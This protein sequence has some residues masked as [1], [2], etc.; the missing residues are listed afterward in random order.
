[1][2]IRTINCVFTGR[3]LATTSGIASLATGQ[4]DV[5]TSTKRGRRHKAACGS[6]LTKRA[7]RLFHARSE[8]TRSATIIGVPLELG[9][10]RRGA[11]LGPHVLRTAGLRQQLENLGYT[12]ADAG[13]V[14]V[15]VDESEPPGGPGHPKHV[16]PV[17]AANRAIADAVEAA[18]RAESY[19]VVIGGDHSMAIGV[20]AGVARV[21]GVQ[22]VIWIDAHADLNTPEGSPT[23]N[24]H[25]M[26]MAAAL[27]LMSD[28]FPPAEFPTPAAA[29]DRLVFI[30]LRDV[31]P[32]ERAVI[33]EHG[34]KCFTMTDVDRLGMGD[35]V[36]QAITIAG[37]G[38]GSVHISFDID[39]L[40]PSF[41]PGTGTPVPG[42][43]TYREAH[44][45]MELI[46]ESGVA[47]SLELSEVNPLLDEHD[48]TAAIANELICS[49]LGKRIL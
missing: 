2:T 1:M 18:M 36:E 22:G 30:G 14:A 31:D 35:V 9:A 11:R 32:T 3:C 15:P 41:A 44:L 13:D 8:S 38:P 34:I 47:N 6:P 4:G 49:A 25:G 17:V 46:A 19:P 7:A 28:V 48:R 27:G 20:I 29:F 33:H 23:G 24:L 43:I 37:R 12:V 45:A 42:G 16:P 39:C 10:S 21:K 26:S 5:S 40:D